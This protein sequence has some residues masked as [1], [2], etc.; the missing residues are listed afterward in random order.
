MTATQALAHPRFHDQLIPNV[1][2]FE[3][4]QEEEKNGSFET[5]A[6]SGIGTGRVRGYDNATVTFMRERGHHVLWVPPG[7][8]SAQ[9]VRLLWNGSWEAVG[10]PRQLD[11]GGLVL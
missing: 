1:V 2:G 8:S 11:S 3:W 4:A 6:E 5:R 9:A 10:E 7:Y